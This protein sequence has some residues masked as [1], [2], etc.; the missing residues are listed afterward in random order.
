LSRR[1]PL[2]GQTEASLKVLLGAATVFAGLQLTWMSLRGGVGR[3]LLQLVVAV[4]ALILG[5][6]T[7]RLLR[8][9]SLSNS[10][11]QR[12]RELIAGVQPGKPSAA[13]GLQACA[14]LFCA[15]PLSMLGS[16]QDGL[17]SYFLPL[18]I[19]AVVDGLA[20]MAFATI[21]GWGVLLASI[22]V[23]AF[24]GTITLACRYLLKPVLSA[25]LID[26]TNAAGGL[27]VFSVALVLLNL[28]KV[29]LAE[30]LPSLVFAPLLTLG[31]L[32]L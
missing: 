4:M 20:A 10:L 25:E 16:V 18:L 31:L 3:V 12:A 8:L 14:I 24:Q 32:Y 13:A 22:P 9:Q 6:L 26:S 28:K 23:L 2:S 30:Y 17:S 29:E 21:F 1:K 19:K 27:V 5:R 7:G 15:A 11:G